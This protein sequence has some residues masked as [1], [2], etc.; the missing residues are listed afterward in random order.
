[1]Y[2]SGLRGQLIIAPN[3]APALA[4]LDASAISGDRNYALPDTS[5]T[6]L[7]VSSGTGNFMDAETPSGTI[8]GSNATFTLANGPVPAASLQLFLNGAYQSADSEDY[9]LAGDTIVFASAPPEGSILRA[10]YR[11]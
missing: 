7:I 10:H 6:L 11:Y 1:M 5:G 8:D 3:S 9:A 2:H 4:T